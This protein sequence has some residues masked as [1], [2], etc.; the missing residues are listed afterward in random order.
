L[1]ELPTRKQGKKMLFHA[2]LMRA[3]EAI[4]AREGVEGVSV[5]A[6]RRSEGGGWS[7]R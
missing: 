7:A 6:L 3:A 5:H 2:E 1:R 4:V